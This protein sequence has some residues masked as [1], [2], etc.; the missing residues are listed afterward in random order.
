MDIGV[1]EPGQRRIDQPVSRQRC[2]PGKSPADDHHGEMAAAVTGAGVADVAVAL[3]SDFQ[4][5]R[6]QRDFQR[7]P[8]RLG[9]AGHGRNGL[10]G[11]TS[12]VS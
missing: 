2:L 5:L 12:T 1:H 11:R 10:N 6:R 9:S 4:M 7:S 8:D 3:V